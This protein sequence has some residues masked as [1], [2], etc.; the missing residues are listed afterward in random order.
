[1]ANCYKV[2]DSCKQTRRPVI[3]PVPCP[4]W[5][6]SSCVQKTFRSLVRS[7]ISEIK[8]RSNK[9]QTWYCSFSYK[10]MSIDKHKYKTTDPWII[11]MQRILI[12]FCSFPPDHAYI[13]HG[14]GFQG[15][16]S[17]SCSSHPL[18]LWDQT[19][20]GYSPFFKKTCPYSDKEIF[21]KLI[22]IK[23]IRL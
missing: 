14:T 10:I 2:S 11:I 19:P 4:C 17:F 18:D 6:G 13:Q 16:V 23:C 15:V 7:F 5:H 1:M 9:A 21:I 12:K 22:Y 20:Y 8:W 3:V